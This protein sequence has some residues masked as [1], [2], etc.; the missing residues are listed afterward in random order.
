MAGKCTGQGPGVGAG[1]D[2][3]REGHHLRHSTR[4]AT[5]GII[6]TTTARHFARKSQS[7]LLLQLSKNM[8]N[9]HSPI[10]TVK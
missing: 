8:Q 5:V 1:P 3:L 2:N 6:A 7:V 4:K 9:L 10:S